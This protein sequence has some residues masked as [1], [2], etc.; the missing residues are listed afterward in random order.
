MNARKQSKKIPEQSPGIKYTPVLVVTVLTLMIAGIM[1]YSSLMGRN[2]AERYAPM[3]DATMEIKIE[4]IKAHLEL[5]EVISGNQNLTI[6]HAWEHLTHA[7]WYAKA[8]LEGGE[9]HHGK[10]LPLTDPDL[11]H[12][13]EQTLESISTFRVKAQNIWKKHSQSELSDID[14]HFHHMFDNILTYADDV[15]PALKKMMERQLLRFSVLQ[16]MLIAIVLI[17][18]I[19]IG[20][21]LQCYERRR[22][23]NMVILQD[24]EENL[25]ITINSIG[26]AVI[27][28]DTQ[29]NIMRMNPMAEELTGWTF[30]EAK[31][32]ALT[33]VFNIVDAR[34]KKA[35]VNPVT[36][37]L[38]HGKIVG[39]ANHTVLIAKD[40][41]ER[42]IADSAAPIRDIDGVITGV[43]LVFRD[44]TESYRMQEELRKNEQE[45][46]TLTENMPGIVYRV[47]SK[48]NSRMIFFNDFVTAI[49]GYKPEELIKG[50]ICSIESHIHQEDRDQTMTAVKQAIKDKVT[51]EVE[52]RFIHKNGGI[53]HFSEVGKPIFDSDGALLSID[54][55]I[56]DITERKKLKQQIQFAFSALAEHRDKL[57]EEVSE[58]TEELRKSNKELEQF[59]YVASHDLQEPLRMVASYTQLLEKRYKDK[60]DDK[61]R[62]FIH[63]AVDGAQRM[64]KLINDLLKYSRVGTKAKPFETVNLNGIYNHVLQNL[65]IIITETNTKISCQKLPTVEADDVQMIQLFQNLISNAIKFRSERPPVIHISVEEKEKNWVFSVADNGIGIDE[66]YNDKI[67][68]IF[69]QLHGPAEYKGTGIGLAVCKK[70]IERHRG[71]IWFQSKSGEGTTFFYKIP[72]S[73]KRVSLYPK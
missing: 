7:E 56:F 63:F 55:I 29:S 18:G 37:V 61:A 14:L 60:L 9:S 53:R 65:K 45:Y 35:G 50:E 26:D 51:F 20:V 64:Q 40:K 17:L 66:K 58:R 33:E 62:E 25:R 41:T 12:T 59:A 4:V 57:E 24:K 8:M 34:T 15:E 19:I 69:Q 5:M 32:K 73:E 39:L 10:F 1:I 31:G 72:K 38:E 13:V 16:G 70:I 67:F 30:E 68:T 47:L 48:E 71:N 44:V 22:T 52:Y 11:R 3:I 46:R 36:R 42:Q 21:V 54:G 27:T 28:T 6:E 43:V 49:T 2:I 23:K